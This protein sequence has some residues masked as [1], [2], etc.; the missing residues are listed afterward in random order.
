MSTWKDE[1]DAKRDAS[2]L[3]RL[4]RALAAPAPRGEL[5][6]SAM[7][8]QQHVASVAL[9]LEALEYL[10]V[11]KGTLAEN[12]LMEALTLLLKQKADQVKAA[13]AV[14]ETK[15]EQSH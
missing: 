12:E 7:E 3:K 1:R 9:A 15:N 11:Q 13:D 5:Y 6:K 8:L 2:R 14:Q 10:L 4:S